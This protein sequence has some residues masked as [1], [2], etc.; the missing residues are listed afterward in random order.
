MNELEANIVLSLVNQPGLVQTNEVQPTWFRD[1]RLAKLVRFLNDTHGDFKGFASLRAS[2]NQAYPNVIREQDWATLAKSQ[3][4][5]YQFK[6]YLRDLKQTYLRTQL[7]HAATNYSLNPSGNNYQQLKQ[8]LEDLSEPD[9]KPEASIKDIGKK[10]DYDLDHSVKPGIKTFGML[11][12]FAHNGLRGGNLLTIGARPSV[13]KSAF[14]VN[15]ALRALGE[16]NG[17]M[18]VDFFSLEMSNEDVYKR[19]TSI[20]TGI[21]KN[22]FVNPKLQLKDDQKAKVRESI[23]YFND[24]GL[25]IHENFMTIEEITA[26]IQ[27]RAATA[28]Q[29]RYLA[30]VD[31][32]QLVESA[33]FRDNRQQQ[34]AL[35]SRQLKVLTQT[36]NIPIVMLSQLNRGVESRMDKTPTMS[37]LRETGAIEQDSNMIA[38]LYREDDQNADKQEEVIIFD[39]QKNR[40]GMLG[41]SKLRFI[42]QNQTMRETF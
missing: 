6:G 14:A 19:L 2:F 8:R 35:V 23:K 9:A 34:V 15:L 42:K 39:M 24:R 12:D 28:R 25:E 18:T 20:K 37:D 7:G 33:R 31:Y 27:E 41:K 4:Y 11:D 32:L 38:F 29:G 22:L 40:E 3:S 17:D 16:N 5:N 26:K 13:G 1:G 10:L 36:L 21:P 30:I